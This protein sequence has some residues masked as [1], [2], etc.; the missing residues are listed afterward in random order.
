M[1]YQ[2]D[3]ERQRAGYSSGLGVVKERADNT[4]VTDAIFTQSRWTGP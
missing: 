1:R 3:L 2:A 4:F